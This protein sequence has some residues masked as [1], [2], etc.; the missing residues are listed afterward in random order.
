MFGG[1]DKF[2]LFRAVGGVTGN[3]E[4]GGE[5]S[6]LT[7]LAGPNKDGGAE[8]GCSEFVPFRVV[9]MGGGMLL[10]FVVIG[11][12]LETAVLWSIGERMLGGDMSGNGEDNGI[13]E[14]FEKREGKAETDCIDDFVKSDEGEGSMPSGSVFLEVGKGCGVV[15]S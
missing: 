1:G 13:N 6:A 4:G 15:L 2:L 5:R 8:C 7:G 10:N 12:R 11:A 3:A 14:D 9:E